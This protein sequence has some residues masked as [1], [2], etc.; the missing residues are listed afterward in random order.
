M[1]L[2]ESGQMYLE[3]IYVLSKESKYVRAIDVGEHLGYSKPSVSR[4]MSILKKDGYVSVDADGYL[5]LTESGR[6][7]A[8]SMYCRHTVL[9]RLLVC[10]GVDEKIAVEDACRIEHVISEESFAAMKA[11]LERFDPKRD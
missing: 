10:L 4:A 7:V 11:H 2:H 1:S 9:S 3:T 6:A 5:T 8:E